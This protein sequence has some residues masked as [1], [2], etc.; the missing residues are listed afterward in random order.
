VGLVYV[1]GL[2]LLPC[3][4][5]WVGVVVFFLFSFFFP[6]FLLD[7]DLNASQTSLPSLVGGHS[8]DVDHTPTHI[9]DVN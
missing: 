5:L 8:S 1:G 4:A 3:F 2:W 9:L 6:F 7:L